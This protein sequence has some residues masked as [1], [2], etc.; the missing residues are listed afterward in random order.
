MNNYVPDNYDLWERHEEEREAEAVLLPE[1]SVCGEK[2]QDEFCYEINDEL[3]C[4]L[5]MNGEFRK[6]TTDFIG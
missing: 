2:I 1:C 6:L 3:I 4:E 5:C